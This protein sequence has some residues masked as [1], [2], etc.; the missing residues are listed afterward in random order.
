[1]IRSLELGPE[2]QSAFQA[3]MRTDS[4]SEYHILKSF[5]KSSEQ[6]NKV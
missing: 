3:S 6:N 1:M 4:Y 2:M 5:V